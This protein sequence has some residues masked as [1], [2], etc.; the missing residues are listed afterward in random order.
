MGP[1]VYFDGKIVP[2]GSYAVYSFADVH[3]DESIYPDPWRFDPDRPEPKAT[4]GWVGWGGGAHAFRV[5]HYRT[6][7]LTSLQARTSVKALAL[8]N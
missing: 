6:D 5:P 3:L 1:D 7:L 4:M 8:R 2:S